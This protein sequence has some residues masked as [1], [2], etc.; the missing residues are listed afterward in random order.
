MYEFANHGWMWEGGFG[1]MSWAGIVF[2]FYLVV[3][4]LNDLKKRR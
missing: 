4:W 1:I 3:T 2:I